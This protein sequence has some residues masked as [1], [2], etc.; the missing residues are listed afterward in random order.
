MRLFA[1]MLAAAMP[2]VA[3]AASKVSLVSDVFV[4]RVG[5]DASGRP[6]RTLSPPRA[7]TPG[8][9][10]V[11]VLSYRNGGAEPASG[12]V[13]T[14]PVPDSVAFAGAED[15]EAEVSVDWGRSWGKLGALSVTGAD[16]GSRPAVPEDVTHVRWRL[17]DSVAAGAMGKLS[18]RAIAR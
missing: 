13:I 12:F 15:N 16:G 6:V 1:T 17:R 11:F 2:G 18:Y 5:E 14:N 10:L 7:L 3:A 8:D 9:R 4:E